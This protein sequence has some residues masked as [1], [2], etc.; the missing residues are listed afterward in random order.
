MKNKADNALITFEEIVM[1]MIRNGESPHGWQNKKSSHHGAYVK[2]ASKLVLITFFRT[3]STTYC[4]FLFI[5]VWKY[6][7]EGK[8][9]GKRHLI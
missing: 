8:N 3:A 5:V 2:T 4:I 1:V 7:S 9:A 6:V